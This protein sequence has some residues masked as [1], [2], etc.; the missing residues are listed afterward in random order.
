MWLVEPVERER[1]G[2][3]RKLI[4]QRDKVSFDIGGRHRGHREHMVFDAVAFDVVE[5]KILQ[6]V[7]QGR[8][9]MGEAVPTVLP[10]V[11]VV[12]VVQEVVVQESRTN[13][14]PEIHVV[15]EMCA[16]RQPNGEARHT[17]GMLECG[18]IAVLIAA[19]FDLHV[20][21][22]DDFTAMLGD[23]ALNLRS[24]EQASH[25]FVLPVRAGSV[26]SM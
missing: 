12:P 13:Q 9:A 18:D 15:P 14:R 26:H 1:F 6:S 3:G 2:G 21:M 24:S 7:H 23:Q 17:Y 25:G 22:F 16:I 5:V 19:T 11:P 8:M 10:I 4:R 20:L